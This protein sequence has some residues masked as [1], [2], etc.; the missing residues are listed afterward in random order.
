[1]IPV[2]TVFMLALLAGG[3]AGTRSQTIES[4][5]P[6]LRDRRGAV[7]MRLRVI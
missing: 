1:M 6:T 3:C 4:Q 7:R 2:R 5:T